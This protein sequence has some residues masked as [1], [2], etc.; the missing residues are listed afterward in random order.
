M[1]VITE[2]YATR[3]HANVVPTFSRISGYDGSVIPL[4]GET[5][6]NIQLNDV[7]IRHKFLVVKRSKNNLL[8]RD[9][10]S[11]LKIYVV[12]DH[13]RVASV[14]QSV[15]DEFSYYFS[16][17]FKTCVSEEVHIELDKHAQPIFMKARQI[18]VRL[19]H[20]VSNEIQRLVNDGI[21]EKV[22]SAEW[23]SPIVVVYKKDSGGLRLC[24]DISA[25][26]NKYLKPVKAP[27]ITVDEAIASVGQA[28]VFSK[29]DL[30]SAFLQLPVHKDSRKYLV[31]N[32]PDGLFQFNYLPFGLTVS[33]GIFQAFIS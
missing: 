31:I 5:N 10:F 25:S 28:K 29:L 16:N 33:P 1:C 12:F 18:P 32:K 26:V 2:D 19:R 4:V 9:I 17:N 13:N 7:S 14:S 24:A 11:K 8:D 6:L 27:L 21:L 3:L 30:A 23:A 15:I 20:A 22:Y